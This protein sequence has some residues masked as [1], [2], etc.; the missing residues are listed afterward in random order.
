MAFYGVLL[1]GGIAGQLNDE[2]RKIVNWRTGRKSSDA[3]VV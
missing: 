3:F 1:A 2:I